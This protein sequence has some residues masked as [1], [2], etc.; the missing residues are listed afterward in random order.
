MYTCTYRYLYIYIVPLPPRYYNAIVAN[1]NRHNITREVCSGKTHASGVCVQSA[2]LIYARA[3]NYNVLALFII[4][5]VINYYIRFCQTRFAARRKRH[6]RTVIRAINA[7]RRQKKI[8]PCTAEDDYN[9][10]AQ[11]KMLIRPN[12]F[13]CL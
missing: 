5:T 3:R 2:E 11:R 9:M 1:I 13:R 7:K 10:R 8:V 6:V 12:D 4:I